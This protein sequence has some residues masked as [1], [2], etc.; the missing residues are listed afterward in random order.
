MVDPNLI[1]DRSWPLFNPADF[2]DD[3]KGRDPERAL[4]WVGDQSEWHV[5]GDPKF[6]G[7]I[8]KGQQGFRRFAEVSL[9]FFPNSLERLWHRVWH[10]PGA[11]I[12]EQRMRGEAITGR[13]YVNNYV[14]VFVHGKD[15]QLLEVREY[16]DMLP[17]HEA[18]KGWEG[19]L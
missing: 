14:F 7:T 18:M 6:G 10:S 8:Y 13:E 19:A 17:L 9:S 3:L 4:A 11:T 5:P 2:M 1:S 16:Q 15:G 12:L